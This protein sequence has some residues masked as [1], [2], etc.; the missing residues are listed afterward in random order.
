MNGFRLTFFDTPRA[1]MTTALRERL[2]NRTAIR[3]QPTPD[4]QTP[5]ELPDP[6]ELPPA[7]QPPGEQTTPG[8]QPPAEPQTEEP[9]EEQITMDETDIG[10]RLSLPALRFVADQA[11]LLPAER[12]RLNNLA[13][14]LR[15]AMELNPD[16]SFLVVGHTADI[17]LPESQ[18]ELSVERARTIVDTLVDL[19]LPVDRFLFQGRGGSEPAADNATPEGRALNRRVEVYIIE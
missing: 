12:N 18:Q 19:G 8:V 14:A 4:E 1:R 11:V 9:V 13:E 16:S 17:G 15:E 7:E 5:A 2:E 10:L 6:Q 3:R